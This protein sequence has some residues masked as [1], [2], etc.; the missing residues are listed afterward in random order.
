MLLFAV[1]E[2]NKDIIKLLLKA[3]DPDI[4]DRKLSQTALSRA[5]QDRQ[6]AIFQQLLDT[7]RAD[8][9]SKD[10]HS[11]TPLS[12]AAGNGHKA[13]VK[14]LPATSQIEIDLKDKNGQMGSLIGCSKWAQ[15]H[16]KPAARD[17]PGRS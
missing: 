3:V 14:L 6:E 4:K 12:W 1:R 5:A 8:I 2:G 7:G 17:R 10:A 15:S 16:H 9:D 13:V 11:R